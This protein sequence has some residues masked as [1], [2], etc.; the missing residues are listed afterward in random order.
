MN[1][2]IGCSVVATI[3]S[4]LLATATYASEVITFESPLTPVIYYP[5]N[6]LIDGAFSISISGDPLSARAAIGPGFCSPPCSSNG[7]QS[8]YSMATNFTI[9]RT[10]GGAFSLLSLDA[11]SYFTT[12]NSTL[13]IVVTG[14]KESASVVSTTITSAPGGA[15]VFHTYTLAGFDDLNSFTIAEVSNGINYAGFA[16]DNITA[17]VPEPSTWAMMILGFAGIGF[18]A[19]RRSSKPAVRAA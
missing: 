10:D 8:L 15:D 14:Y 7:T 1:R 16:V 18:M 11:A 13:D 19:Y 5:G 12:L 3:L 17:D 6:A 4:S 2:I 9:L